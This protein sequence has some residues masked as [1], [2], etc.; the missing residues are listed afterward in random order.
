MESLQPLIDLL[1]ARHGWIPAVLGWMSAIRLA[2]KWFSGGLQE[3]LTARLVEAAKSADTQDDA[4]WE[5]ILRA[6]W[7][8]WVSFWLDLVFSV[9]L[10]TYSLFLSTKPTAM[11]HIPLIFAAAGLLAFAGCMNFSNRVFRLEQATSHLA[12]TAYQGWTNH[13]ALHSVSPEASNA[14]KQARIRLGATLETTEALRASLETNSAAKPQLTAT[15]Q[16]LAD[17]SSNVV[18]LI[19]YWRAQ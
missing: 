19:N 2:L 14:V 4:D 6:R 9:K 7:Y 8:R 13:M 16:T 3:R 18:W 15:L 17:H 5:A 1:S 10:P 12:V 11:K